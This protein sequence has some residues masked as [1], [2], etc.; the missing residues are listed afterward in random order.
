MGRRRKKRGF[1]LNLDAQTQKGIAT[2]ALF[3]VAVFL[4][5]S[6]FD[7]AG[8][9]GAALDSALAH[10]FGWD[11][12]ILPFFLFAM[13]IYLYKPEKLPLKLS[14]GI[15]FLLFFIG[16]N[17]M[18]HLLTF[19]DGKAAPQAIDAAAGKLG[20]M[21]GQPF[22]PLFGVAG[23]VIFFG[24][25]FATSLVLIFNTSLST[26]GDWLMVIVNFFL[27]VFSFIFKPLV[28]IFAAYK[29]RR[30]AKVEEQ[31]EAEDEEEG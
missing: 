24:A 3:A 14:N 11:K 27:R 28:N 5:L 9:V 18:V 19:G 17:P 22:I 4:L 29:E 13:A 10:V 2:V 6:L 15:G 8:S 25:I 1:K 26:I 16:L 30:Q 20:L 23:A 7:L 21:L 12:I 31:D